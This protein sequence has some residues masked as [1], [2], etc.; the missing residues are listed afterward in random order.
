MAGKVWQCRRGGGARDEKRVEFASAH[1]AQVG[2][3]ACRRLRGASDLRSVARE[4]CMASV[5]AFVGGVLRRARC[6]SKSPPRRMKGIVVLAV[7]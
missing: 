5:R 7:G 1:E 4:E 2:G 3:E 6:H